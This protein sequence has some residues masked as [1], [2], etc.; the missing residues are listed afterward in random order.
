MYNQ[1]KW[2]NV[3]VWTFILLIMVNSIDQRPITNVITAF[4]LLTISVA[5]VYCTSKDY[6]YLTF[7]ILIVILPLL[8]TL[9]FK[10]YNDLLNESTYLFMARLMSAINISNAHSYFKKHPERED[11]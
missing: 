4:L 6:K 7:N 1:K 5:S 2:L 11:E 3:L 10:Y 8:N 9:F